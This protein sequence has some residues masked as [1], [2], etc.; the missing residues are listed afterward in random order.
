MRMLALFGAFLLIFI[1]VFQGY[2]EKQNWFEIERV[3]VEGDLTYTSKPELHDSYRSLI[4]QNLT[5]LSLPDVMSLAISPAWVRSAS[6]RKVWPNAIL[7][8]V[9]EHAPLA[10]WGERQLIATGGKIISPL[11]VPNVPLPRLFGPDGTQKSVLEQF[12]LVSQVL[13]STDLR[14]MKLALEARGAWSVTLSNGL[15]VRLGREDVL[16]RLQRFIAVYKSDLSGRI[17]Q[18][19]GVDARYPHGVSVAW[20]KEVL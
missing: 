14:P 6:V 7:V 15:F 18:I 20:K 9:E 10:I 4:G 5:S 13:S 8:R 16:E 1:A 19:V 11:V 12:E 3:I 17:D 2:I